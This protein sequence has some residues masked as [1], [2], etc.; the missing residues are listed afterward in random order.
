MKMIIETTTQNNATDDNDD[1]SVKIDID[2][3]AANNDKLM[4]N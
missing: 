4:I 1:L 3:F 2:T